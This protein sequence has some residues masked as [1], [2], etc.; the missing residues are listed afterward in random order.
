MQG[1]I[2]SQIRVAAEIFRTAT[3][4]SML[5]MR[6]RDVVLFDPW[7]RIR[8]GD[9]I[10]FRIRDKHPSHF[11]ENLESLGYKVLRIRIRDPGLGAFLTPGSGIRDGRKSASG[12]GI[13]DE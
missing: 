4:Q 3:V 9:K 5:R 10:R 11:S 2:L 12:S 6:N 8:D 7:I 1:Q 13:R